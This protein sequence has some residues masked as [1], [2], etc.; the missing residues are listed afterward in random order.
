MKKYF[1]L[2]F[3]TIFFSLALAAQNL[4]VIVNYVTA[5]PTI[6]KPLIYYSPAVKLN[7]GDFNAQ[8]DL[9]DDAAAVTNAGIGFRM[10][11]HSEGDVATLSVSVS[12]NFSKTDSWVKDNR[13]TAYIL[14]HEQ[15][16]FDI[17]YIQAMMFVQNLKNAKYTSKNFNTVI[18]KLYTDAQQS[19]VAMQTAYDTETKHSQLLEVQELWNKKID[20]QLDMI[21]K[22]KA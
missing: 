8:P 3:I 1:S 2:L 4:Q 20:F 14:N 18:K 5:D 10:A 16:H 17:A 22:L 12:C 6:H 21:K 11:F 13:R 15:H 19:L 7:W 9:E